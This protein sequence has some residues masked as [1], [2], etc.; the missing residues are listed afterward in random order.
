MSWIE[1]QVNHTQKAG[2]SDAGKVPVRVEA[3]VEQ[4][5]QNM[6]AG[7][8]EDVEEFKRLNGDASFEQDYEFQC[9]VSN[10]AAK[11]TAVV[12][13]DITAQTISYT[14]EPEDE[15]TAVPEKGI[16]SLRGEGGSM[17]IFSADQQL[18]LEQARRLILE[19]LLFS[20]GGN[21]PGANEDA[22]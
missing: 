18:T 5:W 11:T 12:T 7:F 19:P 1:D 4:V 17:Q 22:A 2:E 6:V 15:K 16:L 9:H 8:R 13:A 14:Y 20:P 10:P 3:Q 21:I